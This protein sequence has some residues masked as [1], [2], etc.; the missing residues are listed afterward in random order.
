[1]RTKVG[2]CSCLSI[3]NKWRC[4]GFKRNT[5]DITE[6]KLA[7]EGNAK[8]HSETGV[9]LKLKKKVTISLETILK[10]PLMMGFCADENRILSK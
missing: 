5:Q 6:K 7:S 1:V 9:K 3:V 4:S 2:S 8:K 10:I